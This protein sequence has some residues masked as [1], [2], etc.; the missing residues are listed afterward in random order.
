[1]KKITY[2]L[3]IL[4][5]V[6]SAC[7]ESFDPKLDSGY[8]RLVVQG[9]ISSDLKAHQVT[10]TKSADYFA[11]T[12]A[13]RVT[14]AVVSISD[15]ENSFDLTEVSDG[16]YET[17]PIAGVPGKTYTLLINTDNE[18]YIASCYLNYCPPIDSINFG[19]YDLSDYDIIDSSASVLLN[20]QEPEIPNN[21]Y[22]WNVYRNGVLETD[23]LSE[24]SFAD[25]EFI[26]GNYMID[27]EVGWI[28]K[29][30]VGDT[31]D[32]EMLSIT[33]GYF[34]YLSQ[35]LSVTVWDAGP[36]GGPPANPT[37]NIKEL[38]DDGNKNN[39]PLGFF[40]AYSNFIITDTIPQKDE[41]IELEWF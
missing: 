20:A 2:I 16:L 11:N 26:N 17:D 35:V 10:L 31:I 18:D 30:E 7:T 38:I 36:F 12:P 23:T 33:E 29:A 19:Y 5:I 21:Y 34:N 22:M 24:H 6:V 15:G 25:D 3:L 9:S 14:G 27:V 13:P 1:M 40:L 32:L 39:D 28:R 8:I 4:T 41:W 37:G